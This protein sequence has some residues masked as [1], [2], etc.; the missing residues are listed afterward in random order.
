MSKI[1]TSIQ[2]ALE[3]TRGAARDS[4][5]DRNKQSG[6][7]NR[8]EQ[9]DRRDKPTTSGVYRIFQFAH[10]QEKTMEESR[11]VAAVE[12]RVAKS[13]YNLLR[14]RVLHRMR[15]NSWR[16]LLVTSPGPGE[17]KTLTAA[18]LA[19]SLSG[20]VNQTV[21]L[22]D[23]DLQRSS[24]ARYLGIEVDTKSG[25]G[26]F[27]QGNAEISDIVY[28]PDDMARI[29]LLPNR[30][31][32]DNPSDLLGSPRMKE[33]VAWLREQSDKS[34]VIFDMPPVLAC[35][36]VL[37][38]CPEVDAILLIAAQGITERSGLEKSVE[39]LADYNL[40]GVVLNKATQ[41]EGNDSYSYY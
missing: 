22:V 23:L 2:K 36:D 31:P 10:P 20:D 29:S 8:R 17:G 21:I 32:V 15:N 14:T 7:Q 28:T 18:N 12:D 35:D 39:L 6:Q 13:A 1:Q 24:I 27:L 4:T 11:I 40:L 26:D 38:F 16:T 9:R 37:A 34:I 3:K 19:I 30:E 5:Q 41:P 33:L 25:V